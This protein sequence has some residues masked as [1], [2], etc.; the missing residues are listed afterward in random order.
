MSIT[1]FLTSS[2]Y[3][4]EINVINL[5]LINLKYLDTFLTKKFSTLSTLYKLNSD[6]LKVKK[7]IKIC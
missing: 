4:L 2:I 6:C 3:N 1:N 5:L 7:L